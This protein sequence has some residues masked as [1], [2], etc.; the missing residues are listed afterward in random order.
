MTVHHFAL[1]T[2][3]AK[4]GDRPRVMNNGNHAQIDDFV[5]QQRLSVQQIEQHTQPRL[6]PLGEIGVKP[7]RLSSAIGDCWR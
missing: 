6:T 1:I 7:C 5:A 3:F 2:R 4:H